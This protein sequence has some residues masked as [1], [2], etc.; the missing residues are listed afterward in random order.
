M[1]GNTVTAIFALGS[2]SGAG[3]YPVLETN[4]TYY[5]NIRNDPGSNCVAGSACDMSIDLIKGPL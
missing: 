3:Y 1:N 4:T 2:G 5:L